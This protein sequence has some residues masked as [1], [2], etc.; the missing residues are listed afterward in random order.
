MKSFMNKD[1]EKEIRRLLELYYEGMTSKSEEK[2]LSRLLAEAEDLP[3]DLATDRRLFEV[4]SAELEMKLPADKEEELMAAMERE[5]DAEPRRSAWRRLWPVAAAIA[6]CLLLGWLS[7]RLVTPDTPR[8]Q[9]PNVMAKGMTDQPAAS[10]TAVTYL[11][12]AN[13]EKHN[14]SDREKTTVATT[15]NGRTEKKH[16]R[17]TASVVKAADENNR[18]EEIYY[19]S[20]EEEEQLVA[21]NYRVVSDEREAYAIMNSVFSRLD[22]NIQE[23]SYRIDDISDKYERV[24][25]KF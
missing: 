11:H 20:R 8:Q 24:S 17:K 2:R 22:G 1:K 12:M 18:E 14:I 25:T 13:V 16:V 9:S 3:Q 7:L 21:R 23:S 6:A 10:D 5:I 19:L 15:D 4:L